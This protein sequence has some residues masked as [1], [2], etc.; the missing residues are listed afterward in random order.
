MYCCVHYRRGDSQAGLGFV[1]ACGVLRQLS[2]MAGPGVLQG[3][4]Q[5]V[6]SVL[7]SLEGKFV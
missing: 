1:G 5:D 7:V 4:G 2:V 3:V 6:S